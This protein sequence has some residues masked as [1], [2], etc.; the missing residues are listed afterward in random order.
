MRAIA[1]L[2]NDKLTDYFPE[3]CMTM[4]A[5]LWHLNQM[6]VLKS[7]RARPVD[8]TNFW[9][10]VSEIAPANHC[11]D[12]RDKVYVFLGLLDDEKTMIEADYSLET[13][14]ALS[15]IATTIINAYANL[16]ILALAAREGCDESVEAGFSS[17]V[18]DW[19]RA[20]LCAPICSMSRKT[21]F[22]AA[23]NRA[24]TAIP[25]S[26]EHELHVR[27]RFVDQTLAVDDEMFT[28]DQHW[29]CRDVFAFLQIHNIIIK[30]SKLKL[31]TS[32][33]M[34]HFTI[35]GVLRVALAD[36][37]LVAEHGLTQQDIPNLANAYL[38]YELV[39]PMDRMLYHS[40]DVHFVRSVSRITMNR[41]I[42]VGHSLYLGLVHK[43]VRKDG[44]VC[45]LHGSRTPVML[46]LVDAADGGEIKFR[47]LVSVIWRIGCM[48]R[49]LIGRKMMLIRI[50]LF[51]SR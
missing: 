40:N 38:A 32:Q 51:E 31:D 48:V 45:I 30:F 22:K 7:H 5:G 28:S 6:A 11:R 16:D 50:A 34:P 9:E 25:R 15:R 20:E 26:L 13:M 27:G 33:A 47:F 41:R 12:P 29:T 39:A 49:L 24:H 42:A 46:P 3:R 1:R 43:N 19:S 10:F 18:P 21:S 17:W 36:G 4:V 14:T 2:E 23:D 8:K 44:L 35:E 37:A